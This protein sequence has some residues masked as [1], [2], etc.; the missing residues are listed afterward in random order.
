MLNDG[1]P[2]VTGAATPLGPPN[3]DTI[4]TGGGY[5]PCD[6]IPN[7]PACNPGGAMIVVD[8]VEA[9]VSRFE[10]DTKPDGSISPWG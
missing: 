7:K 4:P 3:P 8:T 5:S 2:L 10:V 9:D 1:G 6:G